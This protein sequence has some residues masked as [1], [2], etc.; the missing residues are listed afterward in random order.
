MNKSGL[1]QI[2]LCGLGG[3]ATPGKFC[4]IYSYLM[5]IVFLAF[6]LTQKL[7][8]KNEH[9]FSSKTGNLIIN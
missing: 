9:F 2:Q 1:F 7:L 8:C 4:I 5:E 3:S 6:I